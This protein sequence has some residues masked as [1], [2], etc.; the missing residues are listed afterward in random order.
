MSGSSLDGLDIAHCNITILSDRQKLTPADLRFKIVRAITIPFDNRLKDRLA[1]AH[2]YK[3]HKLLALHA[4]LGQWIAQMMTKH[5]DLNYI[6]LIA[7]HGHTIHHAPHKGYSLQIGSGAQIAAR[8]GVPT[9][10]NF[11]ATDIALGGQ[12]AP[13]APMADYFL[14]PK[15][16]H[17][18]N[19]GG[20]ANISIIHDTDIKGYDI[21]ACNQVLNHLANQLGHDYDDGGQIAASGHPIPALKK[22][23]DHI[24]YHKLKGAKSL[25]NQYVRKHIIQVVQS[26]PGTIQD[27]LHTAVRHISGLIAK[28]IDTASHDKILITGGGAYNS[29]LIKQIK[30]QSNKKFELPADQIIQFKEALLMALLGV[31]RFYNR[32]NIFKSCTGAIR[33]SSSG[34]LYLP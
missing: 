16:N 21:C 26:H 5:F 3:S 11:R 7:S 17:F 27:K 20:I 13:L 23:L 19:L 6:D 33:D 2:S 32:I 31:L 8:T 15:Y 30:Q 34:S 14:F 4:S 25:S 9:I 29:Y 1:D 28:A 10:D 22:E 12:G 24:A 18:I